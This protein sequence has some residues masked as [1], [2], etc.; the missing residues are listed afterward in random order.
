MGDASAVA[1]GGDS[2]KGSANFDSYIG[3][4]ISLTSKSDI[5]YEGVLY[6]IDAENCNIA[7]QNVR[8]YGTEGRKKEGPQIPPRD[9]VYDYIIFRGSDIKDLQVK[10]SPQAHAV[11]SQPYNDPA[12]IAQ[13]Q[14]PQK[15]QRM[16]Q[17]IMAPPI[18]MPQPPSGGV[19]PPQ[20]P[21]G[22]SHA[23]AIPHP[24]VGM[25]PPRDSQALL[26]P[27][28]LSSSYPPAVGL[29]AWGPRPPPPVGNALYW[30]GYYPPP[31]GNA[32]QPPYLPSQPLLPPDQ[33]P[34]PQVSQPSSTHPTGPPET[35]KPRETTSSVG[36]TA[37][38]TP[39]AKLPR[40][41]S[42]SQAPLDSSQE[43]KK[44]TPTPLEQPPVEG[45]E[46]SKLQPAENSLQESSSHSK[47]QQANNGPRP[48]NLRHEG[49]RHDGQ[50]H[51]YNGRYNWRGNGR[52][53]G[54]GRGPSQRT[55]FTEDFDFMAMNEKFNKDEVWGE[56][57][58]KVEP[59][60]GEDEPVSENW[61]KP[62]DGKKPVYVKD[63]FFDSLSCDTLDREGGTERPRFSEQ[64]KINT[65]TF[66]DAFLR[67]R[68]RGGYRGGYRGGQFRR[69][70]RPHQPA[71]V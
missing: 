31:S 19:P 18:G 53:G 10:S 3:S 14:Q 58:G 47:E 5:R 37:I 65:E 20:V 27:G 48:E 44:N 7:L 4:L 71:A 15:A 49:P 45:V 52:R 28:F 9:S 59:R 30:P 33:R 32:M 1:P 21:A 41:P 26:P 67:S 54:R 70:G 24:A 12:I 46:P 6:T 39:I 43:L 40:L 16:S 66:G 25:P 23:P 13:S 55:N 50:R 42:V 51:E 22:F 68:G 63:D 62:E 60:N 61:Q 57:G 56:L 8:S 34:P 38:L 11:H 29:G 69:G 17:P 2:S 64:R 36:M 35:E